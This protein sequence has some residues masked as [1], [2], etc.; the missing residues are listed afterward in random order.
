MWSPNHVHDEIM[1]FLAHRWVLVRKIP[2]FLLDFIPQAMDPIGK[3][4]K[5]TKSPTFLTHMDAR[6][7]IS[8]D[9]D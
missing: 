6:V 4:I 5:F 3:V 7:L 1:A 9:L 8:I 2:H